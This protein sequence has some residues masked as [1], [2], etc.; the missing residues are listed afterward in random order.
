[1]KVC[2]RQVLKGEE[3]FHSELALTSED[4]HNDAFEPDVVD[5]ERCKIEVTDTLAGETRPKRE[6]R[7]PAWMKDFDTE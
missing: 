2:K 3:S 7:A 5:D 4:A 6:R 1:M